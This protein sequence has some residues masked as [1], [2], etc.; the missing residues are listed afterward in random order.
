MPAI[1]STSVRLHSEFIR[2]L[3][4][5]V[6]RET[7]RFVPASGVQSAQFDRGHFHFRRATFSSMMKSKCGN[8][9]AKAV[10]DIPEESDHFRFLHTVCLGN[11]MGSVGLILAKI[12]VMRIS[13][14][15]DLSSRSF[16]PLQ[17]FISSRRPIPLLGPSLVLFP[18][19]STSTA[20]VGCLLY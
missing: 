17:R 4:L 9:L 7:D 14:P 2:I 1:A 11:I 8:I 15:V 6:H 3:F 12:S 13:I 18:P 19:C 16:I 10:D 5:Q 20:P